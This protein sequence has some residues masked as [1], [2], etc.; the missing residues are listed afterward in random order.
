MNATPVAASWTLAP[1]LLLR[2]AH[3]TDA[4]TY[5]ASDRVDATSFAQVTCVAALA[6][7]SKLRFVLLKLHARACVIRASVARAFG[8]LLPRHREDY[9]AG[10]VSKSTDDRSA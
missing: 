10:S 3:G 8:N 2:H 1:K 5:I 4:V 6:V 7:R 9:G